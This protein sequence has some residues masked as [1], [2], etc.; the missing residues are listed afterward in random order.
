MN[1][2]LTGVMAAALAATMPF[3]APAFAD[4]RPG[5]VVVMGGTISLTGR[6]ATNAKHFLNARKLYVDELNARGWLLGHKVELK[7]L[8]DK[9]D[10][11]TAI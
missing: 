7:I 2:H 11:R 8:D 10:A 3:T 1:K 5:N 4:H 9:S 6:Y